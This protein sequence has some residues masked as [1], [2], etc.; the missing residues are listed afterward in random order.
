MSGIKRENTS[1]ENRE[2]CHMYGEV[3]WLKVRRLAQQG[4][5]PMRIGHKL[6]I[7]RRT[8]KKL[9]LMPV[10]PRPSP[11]ERRSILDDYKP[12]VDGW[13]GIAP[14]ML[15]VDIERKLRALGYEGSY[16]TLK[17]YVRERKEE[18]FREATVRFETLP[19]QQAQ[20][21]FSQITPRYADG[22]VERLSLYHFVLGFSRW[23]DADVSDSQRRKVLMHSLEQTFWKVGGVVQEVLFDNLA[24]V[25]R[26]ARTLHR[27]GELAEEWMRFSAHYGFETRLSM[28]YRAQ[29]KGKVERPIDPVK[30]F[31]ASEVFLSREHLRKE[32]RMFIEGENKKIHSTTKERPIDRLEKERKFLQSL[33]ERALELARLERRRVSRD[34]FVSIDGIRYSVPWEYVK[35][36]IEVRITETEIQLL[37]RKGGLIASH[38]KMPLSLKDKYPYVVQR[39][40]YE[41]LSGAEEAFSNLEKLNRMG[42]G[43]F[44]VERRPLEEYLEVVE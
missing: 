2:V 44:Y 42:F 29:T 12:M 18:I 20:V 1:S 31:I 10:P 33:P 35:K 30:R 43:P 38:R 15:A 21:D 11:R 37:S 32:L 23:K 5:K 19:G 7:D 24:P 26:R 4:F 40:H 13:L 16:S 34:C 25:A 6:G 14:E 9:L 28:A 39:E 36:E 17:R 41:G 22:T 3:E 8:V 27:E